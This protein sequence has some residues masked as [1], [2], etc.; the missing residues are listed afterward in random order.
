MV[1][2]QFNVPNPTNQPL[3]RK[4]RVWPW[5]L[6]VV[7]LVCGGGSV[8]AITAIGG[9]AKVIQQ[10]TASRAADITVTGCTKTIISTVEVSY[11]LTNSATVSRTYLPEFRLQTADGTIVGQ[12]ADVTPEVPAGSTYK[13]KA[14]GTI[15]DAAKKFT[16]KLVSS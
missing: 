9:G 2:D 14:V 3:R 6:L 7:L 11:T 4:R 15:D 5:I 13:G 8:L 1:Y 16:C 12:A 10:E